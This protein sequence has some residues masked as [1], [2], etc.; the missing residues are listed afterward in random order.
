MVKIRI[1]PKEIISEYADNLKKRFR[2]NKVILF[3]STLTHNFN[4]NKNSDLD[5]IVL[6]NDFKKIGFLKRLELLSHA[7][8]GKSRSIPMDIMGYTPAEFNKLSKKSV[9]LKEAKQNGKVI[10]P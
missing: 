6:S 5:I 7:R 3:G 8:S 2:I 10:W 9:I 1:N 4:K